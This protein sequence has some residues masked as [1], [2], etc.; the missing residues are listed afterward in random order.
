ML[1]RKA[2]RNLSLHWQKGLVLL[3][4]AAAILFVFTWKLGAQPAGMSPSEVKAR[5]SSRLI[6][7]I[8]DNPLYAPHKIAQYTAHRLGHHGTV[9]MR[10]PSL[11][12]ALIALACFFITTRWWFGSTLA[13]FGTVL[14]ASSPWFIIAARSA[15]PDILLL[16][17]LS[18]FASF[19][20]L[21]QTD[22][23]HD[24]ALLLLVVSTALCLYVPGVIWIVIVGVILCWPRLRD[25]IKN[26][27]RF[28]LPLVAFLGVVLLI[29]LVVSLV[30]NTSLIR[31][32]LFL[33]TIWPGSI[34]ELAE[35]VIWA[36]LG[37]FWKVRINLPTTLGNIPVLNGLEIILAA[38][39]IGWLLTQ[40]RRRRT[41][42][43]LGALGVCLLAV[44]LLADYSK[45][46]IAL[47]IVYI[48]VTAGLAYFYG[49]WFRVFP[50]NPFAKALALTTISIVIGLSAI[51]GLRY[52]LVA[53]PSAPETKQ[54]YVLQ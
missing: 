4:I 44:G 34:I 42:L 50:R 11:I 21:E 37:L 23:R 36:G 19:L 48:L 14:F 12:F 13:I 7:R 46:L 18:I 24:L 38:V 9:A 16:A 43:L 39:G 51:Y 27:S 20:W 30:N 45:L 1:L 28:V 32:F 47:P 31:P 53:W 33:P 29:P 15:T 40:F 49:E 8:A 41:Y 25:G 52:S 5:E 22:K 35:S 3:L 17:P 6:S 26:T 10:I 54:I 2:R